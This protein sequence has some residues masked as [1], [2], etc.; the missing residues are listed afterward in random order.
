VEKTNGLTEDRAATAAFRNGRGKTK[1]QED[2]GKRNK[3]RKEGS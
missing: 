2:E 3:K 1:V